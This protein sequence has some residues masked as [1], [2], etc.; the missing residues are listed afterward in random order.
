MMIDMQQ[1]L[2]ACRIFEGAMIDVGQKLSAKDL[3]NNMAKAM[4]FYQHHQDRTTDMRTI[5]QLEKD[6][7]IHDYSGEGGK[8]NLL[9]DPSCAMGLLWI[10][11][12][13]QFQYTLFDALLHPSSDNNGENS[14]EPDESAVAA[15]A[16]VRAY[17]TTLAPYH[18]FALRQIYNVAVTTATPSRHEWL[19]RLGGF[20]M[21]DFGPAQQAATQRDLERLLAIWKPLIEH[22]VHLYDELDLEDLRRV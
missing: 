13:L 19:A 11:R 4:E 7:G 9:K 21:V 2:S 5:L 14:N 15:R 1:L 22:W 3:S 16:A 18:G 6:L 8:L 12:S 10:R 17:Q 20:A